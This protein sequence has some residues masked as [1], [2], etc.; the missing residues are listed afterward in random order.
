MILCVF[1]LRGDF[2]TIQMEQ[3]L[4][5]Y[6]TLRITSA[7]FRTVFVE[8]KRNIPFDSHKSMVSLQEMNGVSMGYHHYER[9][10][11]ERMVE[12]MSGHMHRLLLSHML[13]KNL[14]FSII[15]DGSTDSQETHYLIIYFQILEKDIPV[16]CFYK[17]VETSTDSTAQGYLN[18]IKTA[19]ESEASDFYSYFKRNLVGYASDGEP[20]MSGATGGLIAL[21]R[22]ETN[23]PIIATH[24]MAHRLE[25]VIKKAFKKIPYFETFDGF[26]AD[27]YKF[28]NVKAAKRKAHLKQSSH[29]FSLK[30]YAL[31]YIYEERWIC[32]KRQSVR[33]IIKMW[34]LLVKDLNLISSDRS[35]SD[36][37]KQQAFV[38]EN[39]LRGKNFLII[40]NFVSD[41]L[42]HLSFWSLKMQQRTALLADFGDIRDK[43]TNT[44]EHLKKTIGKDLNMLILNSK[45][46]EDICNSLS[47]FMN[48]VFHI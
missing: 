17:L 37:I 12:S 25:L 43:I 10:G 21:L 45:C 11:A 5:N 47:I 18:T 24:C 30:M 22:K 15:I 14:P 1:R 29:D 32:S 41:V 40:L 31:N 33:S 23:H 7:M 3:D 9:K 42:E 38:L 27:L 4:A 46:D 19:F 44:F 2:E 34:Q 20:V 48:S 36:S 6:M 39:G 35:F 13:S 16:V 28:Y 8:T 26:V